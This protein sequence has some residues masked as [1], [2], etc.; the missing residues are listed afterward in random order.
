MDCS[1]AGSSGIFQAKI[2]EWVTFPSP[3]NLPD[4]GIKPGPPALQVDSIP[5]EPPGISLL[6]FRCWVLRAIEQRWNKTRNDQKVKWGFA[7]RG[8]AL[9]LEIINTYMTSLIP[10][11][12]SKSKKKLKHN[13]SLLHIL[14]S[15]IFLI[16][17]NR[18][19]IIYWDTL[20]FLISTSL[21]SKWNK[22]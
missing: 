20:F 1:P 5:S 16:F 9:L 4:P 3:G 18:G 17:I 22:Q 14:P 2:L 10:S 13:Y 11:N 21:K 6:Y 8:E 7:Y 15:L 19:K 12:I